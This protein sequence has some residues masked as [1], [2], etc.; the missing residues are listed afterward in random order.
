MT[1]VFV[2]SQDS[3]ELRRERLYNG[4]IYVFSPCEASLGLCGLARQLAE[5]AFAPYSPE[6]A[7]NNFEVSEYAAILSELKPKF[8][9]HPESKRWIREIFANFGCDAERPAISTCRGFERPHRMAT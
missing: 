7:Q 1:S 8:I 3:D 9:H 5:E 6:T 4:D 2:D